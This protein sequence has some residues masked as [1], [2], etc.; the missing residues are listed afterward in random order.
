MNKSIV[1]GH[2]VQFLTLINLFGELIIKA[3]NIMKTFWN[4]HSF[5]F[6][7]F[8]SRGII[9]LIEL[10]RPEN[11]ANLDCW[12]SGKFRLCILWSLVWFPEGGNHGIHWWWDLI[13]SKQL[14]SVSVCH[15]QV[16][17]RFYGNLIHK[18]WDVEFFFAAF[19][20]YCHSML[21]FEWLRISVFLFLC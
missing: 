1:D 11:Q 9:L 20:M 10:P 12:H 3:Q 19:C 18:F 21:L 14:S 16:I 7:F 6:F 8:S 15:A 13:R 2:I 17:A 5:F 4:V